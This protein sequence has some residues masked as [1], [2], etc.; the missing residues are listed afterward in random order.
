ASQSL[1]APQRR[2]WDGVPPRVEPQPWVK[3]QPFADFN[4]LNGRV[5][6]GHRDGVASVAVA[7][8]GGTA[9]SGG[10]AGTLRLWD[11]DHA[12]ELRRFEGRRAAVLGVALSPDGTRALSASLDRTVRLWDVE[13]G[14]ELRRYEGFASGVTAVAFAPDGKRFAAACG[15]ERVTHTVKNDNAQ[16]PL[17][18][19]ERRRPRPQDATVHVREVESGQEGL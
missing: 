4:D 19:M 8:D 5:L 6:T 18:H 9:L 16:A 14:K 3:P 17:E 10:F 1:N 7:S 2:P 11:P 15:Y 13:T 12:L